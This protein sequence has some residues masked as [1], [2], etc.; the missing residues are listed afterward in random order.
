LFSIRTNGTGLRQ[1]THTGINSGDPCWSPN[2]RRLAY[3]AFGSAG[4]EIYTIRRD[5]TDRQRLTHNK[6]DD[7]KPDWRPIRHA[8]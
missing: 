8:A 7:V 4:A 6:G 3:S 2:G 5:G 1:I